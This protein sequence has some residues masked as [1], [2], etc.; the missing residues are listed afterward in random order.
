LP[1]PPGV[2]EPG[3]PPGVVV[4]PGVGVGVGAELL[5]PHIEPSMTLLMR[6]TWPLRASRRPWTVA[7]LFSEIDASAI[8]LPWNAVV[9]P[10][11]AEV[12]TRQ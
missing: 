2:V 9:E 4:S 8:R 11:T 12:P 1:E 3:V 7:A 5:V 6:L 10:S